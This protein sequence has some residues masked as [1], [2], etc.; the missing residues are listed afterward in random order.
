MGACGALLGNQCGMLVWCW[1]VGGAAAREDRLD[2]LYFTLSSLIFNKELQEK[3]VEVTLGVWDWQL[4]MPG[5]RVG[6]AH[7]PRAAAS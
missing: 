3:N 7:W 6:Q 4:G 1:C 2:A 5:F